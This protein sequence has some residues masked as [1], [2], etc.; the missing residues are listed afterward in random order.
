LTKKKTTTAAKNGVVTAKRS[1]KAATPKTGGE[2]AEVIKPEPKA[3]KT[4]SKKDTVIALLSAKG[5][6]TLE[7]LMKATGWQA[8]SVRGFLSGTIGRKMGL[9]LESAKGED[10]VRVYALTA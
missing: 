10:G 1:R 5:G 2:S 4:A 6:A 9:K 7:G 8:H 3:S